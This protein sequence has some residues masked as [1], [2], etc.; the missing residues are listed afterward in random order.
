[1]TKESWRIGEELSFLEPVRV[2]GLELP[3][4]F[5]MHAGIPG[6]AGSE[7]RQSNERGMFLA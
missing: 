4:R 3:R 1:M 5:G 2:M 6:L 7:D